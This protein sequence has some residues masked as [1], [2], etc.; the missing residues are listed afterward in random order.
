M[1]MDCIGLPD[2][3]FRWVVS[4]TSSVMHFVLRSHYLARLL[5]FPLPLKNKVF[6]S[7]LRTNL[8][9]VPCVINKYMIMRSLLDPHTLWHFHVSLVSK[10]GF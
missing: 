10:L 7:G 2:M 4:L 6:N 3:I 5:L 1:G 9:L 8:F